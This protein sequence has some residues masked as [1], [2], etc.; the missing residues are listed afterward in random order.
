MTALDAEGDA[1]PNYG[2]EVIPEDVRLDVQLVEP[3]G[4][5]SPAVTATV[6]FGAFSAGSATGFD[7]EAADEVPETALPD[8]ETLALIRGP[9]VESLA[10]TY[11][12]FAAE[13][14]GVSA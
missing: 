8:D 2:Q 3:A 6:G 10:E 14:F 4:G 7:F 9:V 12:A 11:P 13:T 5:A 1:T